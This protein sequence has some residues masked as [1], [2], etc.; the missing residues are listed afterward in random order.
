MTVPGPGTWTLAVWLSDAAGNGSSANAADATLVVPS[1]GEQGGSGNSGGGGSNSGHGESS[2]PQPAL[3]VAAAL[4]RCQLA[5]RVTGPSTGTVY[6]S[7][8]ARYRGKII[9][10]AARR[11][12]LRNGRLR[13]TFNL[14][15]RT[16]DHA[17]IRVSVRLDH[18]AT[19]ITRLGR[20]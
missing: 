14:S 5:V 2:S 6:T 9:A 4:H 12:T 3:H 19:V 7:Y 11:A 8:T 16:A 20:S 18:Y 17:S 15:V 13:V 10:T 1:P